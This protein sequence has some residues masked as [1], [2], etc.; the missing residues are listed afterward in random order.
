[1]S[2]LSASDEIEGEKDEETLR[3][4]KHRIEKA[5]RNNE[6]RAANREKRQALEMYMP[7]G[8]RSLDRQGEELPGFSNTLSSGFGQK[9]NNFQRQEGSNRRGQNN[10]RFVSEWFSHFSHIA[11][12]LFLSFSLNPI[13]S[14][15]LASSLPRTIKTINLLTS[16]QIIPTITLETKIHPW[17]FLPLHPSTEVVIRRK[18]RTRRLMKIFI[19]PGLLRRCRSQLPFYHLKARKLHSTLMIK[20]ILCDERS[21]FK[22]SRRNRRDNILVSSILYFFKALFIHTYS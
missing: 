19:L 10:N 14:F 9:R 11:Y 7:V 21:L 6:N 16:V 3:R 15:S 12:S 8:E 2:S 18:L 13:S 4:E 22:T 17:A 5:K 1:M 20:N